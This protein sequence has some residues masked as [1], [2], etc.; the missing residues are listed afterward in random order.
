L[1]CRFISFWLWSL[2][3]CYFLLQAGSGVAVDDEVNT[4][5]KDVQ[6]KNKYKYVIMRLTPDLTRIV[7]DK[8]ADRSMFN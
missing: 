3:Y 5:L 8:K 7:V 4:V 6:M 1:K 2:A